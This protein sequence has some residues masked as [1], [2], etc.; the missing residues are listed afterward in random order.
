MKGS[1]ACDGSGGAPQACPIST[2]IPIWGAGD[3]FSCL[4][5]EASAF[6]VLKGVCDPGHSY[7]MCVLG[8]GFRL[9]QAPMKPAIP[10]LWQKK[11]RDPKLP[12]L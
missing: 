6:P 9:L 7:F 2:E 8:G 12:G 5:V 1:W 4:Q 3:G 10:K 11:A